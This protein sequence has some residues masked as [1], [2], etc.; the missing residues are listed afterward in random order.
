MRDLS[1]LSAAEGE[2]EVERL[3][4]AEAA[5]PFDLT[6][7]PLLRATLLRLAAEEH[8]LLL[9]MHHIISDGWSMGV[10][11]SEVGALY[12]RLH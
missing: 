11:V 7:G 1:S 5:L 6:T 12:R 4:S 3:A 10:L 9:T 2:I 8:M